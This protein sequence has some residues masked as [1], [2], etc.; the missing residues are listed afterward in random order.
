MRLNTSHI[1]EILNT[2]GFG[3]RQLRDKFLRTQTENALMKKE[4]ESHSWGRCR[5][6]VAA[7]LLGCLCPTTASAG[8]IHLLPL[9]GS[10]IFVPS[11]PVSGVVPNSLPF[12]DTFD[13]YPVWFFFEPSTNGW[14]QAPF[15][16][17]QGEEFGNP[18]EA[19]LQ[20]DLT[21]ENIETR[22]EGLLKLLD[23]SSTIGL[24]VKNPTP[25]G[26]SLAHRIFK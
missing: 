3:G 4:S 7:V 20:D 6:S 15:L 14:K 13:E 18:Y 22:F 17:P 12:T 11:A 25:F 26:I 8:G 23:K 19:H 21:P 1:Y 24:Y 2:Y 10:Y 16:A 9:S 5:I